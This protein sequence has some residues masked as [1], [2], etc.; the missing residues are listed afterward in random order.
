MN[1]LLVVNCA[2]VRLWLAPLRK[3]AAMRTPGLHGLPRFTKD[4]DI[5]VFA[6]TH[7]C[8]DMVRRLELSACV[9]CRLFAPV[10]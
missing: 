9:Q 3:E 5:D 6:E 4:S 10:S 8:C 7:A 1:T 2:H